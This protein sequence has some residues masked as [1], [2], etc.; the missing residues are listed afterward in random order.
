MQ[1]SAALIFGVGAVHS[2]A[3]GAF[4]SGCTKISGSACS[5]LPSGAPPGVLPNYYTGPVYKC[6]GL[7]SNGDHCTIYCTNLSG[8]NLPMPDSAGGGPD[9]RRYCE[10]YP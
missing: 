6:D 3:N 9:P 4:E 10:P 1:S 7:Y 2:L 8:G 5:H